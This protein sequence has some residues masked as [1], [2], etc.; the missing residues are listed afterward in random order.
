VWVFING[1][2]AVDIGGVHG[3]TDGSITL[4]AANATALGL[5]DGGMYSIDM[6]QAERHT[7]ASTYKLT[8]SGFTHTVSTCAPICGDGVVEGNEVCDDG[9]NNGSYGG[10]MPGCK[11]R[12]PY[13]GDHLQQTPPEQC[14]DG[15]NMTTYGGLVLACAPGCTIAPYCGDGTVSNGEECD[16]G[17][18]NGTGYGHCS[19]TCTQGPRCGDGLQQA[20]EQCD[21]G[22]RNG[23]SNDPCQADC[24]L[25]CGNGVID[26]GEECDDGVASNVGGYGKC[27]ASC[28]L[29]PRCGD[30]VKNG[31]EQCDNGKNDGSYGT[32]NPTCT[33]ASFCGD[34]VVNG[35]EQCDQGSANSANAYGKDKCTSACSVAP[36]CGDGIVEPAYGEQ[37]DGDPGCSAQSCTYPIQ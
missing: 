11:A 32:C 36:F 2:L 13:C 3:G 7:S 15:T 18:Q 25:K 29:G 23:S 33:L 9:T 10:C 31:N 37:C 4:N 1:K 17:A 28:K 5:V 12:G 20:A 24:T 14:D 22:V 26:P 27:T 30:G 21:D 6:F 19:T 16:E 35:T 34:G 8:L